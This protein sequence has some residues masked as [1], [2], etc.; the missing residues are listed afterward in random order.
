[1]VVLGGFGVQTRKIT[2]FS[3]SA[4]VVGNRFW[5][6]PSLLELNGVLKTP[7]FNLQGLR[8][9]LMYG[10]EWGGVRGAGFWG[11]GGCVVVILGSK[12]PGSFGA[13]SLIVPRTV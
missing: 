1:M 10:G 7:G 2:K 12:K 5:A 6:K 3:K 11:F 4:R 8:G 13:S 9:T